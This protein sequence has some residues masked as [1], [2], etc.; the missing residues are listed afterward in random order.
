MP[1]PPKAAGSMIWSGRMP[2]DPGSQTLARPG[3]RRNDPPD[4]SRH[5][6]LAEAVA[7]WRGHDWPFQ[8]D[9][10][11][12]LPGHQSYLARYAG[13]SEE[14]TS[15]LQSLMSISYAV[16]CLQNTNPPS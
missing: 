8:P 7:C 1:G 5:G 3:R 4:R 13:R 9:Q 16:F 11:E 2:D 14:H 15:E 10:W 12:A 6:P